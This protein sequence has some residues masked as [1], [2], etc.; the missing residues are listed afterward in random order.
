MTTQTRPGIYRY[1]GKTWEPIIV[2]GVKPT[3][4]RAYYAVR[5]VVRAITWALLAT[6]TVGFIFA[7]VWFIWLVW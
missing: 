1:D 7:G 5:S 6:A 3:R 4:S 2:Q